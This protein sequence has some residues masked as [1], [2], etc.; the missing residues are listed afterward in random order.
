MQFILM[1]QRE[2]PRGTVLFLLLLLFLK[3]EGLKALTFE[4]KSIKSD[5]RDEQT[6][7]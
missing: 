1:D 7:I 4:I 2:I 6:S 3:K 5:V